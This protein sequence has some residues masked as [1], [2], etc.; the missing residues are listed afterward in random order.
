MPSSTNNFHANEL[1]AA[2]SHLDLTISRVVAVASA[3]EALL[4]PA[5]F[6]ILFIP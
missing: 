6:D 3:A 1:A 2:V 5:L 4:F